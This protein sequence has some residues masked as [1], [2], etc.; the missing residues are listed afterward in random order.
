M[1]PPVSAGRKLQLQLPGSTWSAPVLL[2]AAGTHGLLEIDAA[3][4]GPPSWPATP[5]QALERTG[6][7][8]LGLSINSCP[9]VFG[10][11]K[12]LTISPRVLLCNTLPAHAIAYKQHGSAAAGEVVFP[13]DNAPFHWLQPLGSRL[14]SVSVLSSAVDRADDTTEALSRCDWSCAFP[15]ADVGDCTIV[16]KPPD[17]EARRK[18]LF[19]NVDVQ[20]TGAESR[21]VF[22]L[23]DATLAPY[24]IDNLTAHP[25]LISQSACAELEHPRVF[26]EVPPGSRLPFAWEQIA[27]APTVDVHVAGMRV[28]IK[29]D[30]LQLKGQ[31][32]LPPSDRPER[33]RFRTAPDGPIKVLQLL[34]DGPSGRGSVGA[35]PHLSQGGDGR[36]RTTL[37]VA[38]ASLGLSLV[39]RTPRELLYCSASSV[40]LDVT[41]SREHS[42]V[43]LT[44][45][46]LQVDNQLPSAVFPVLLQPSWSA[47]ETAEGRTPPPALELRIQCNFSNPGLAFYETVSLRVQTV[48]LMVDT[49]ARQRSGTNLCLPVPPRTLLYHAAAAVHATSPRSA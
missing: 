6:N 42:S 29:L 28:A 45:R 24:R 14:L 48:Q 5:G 3:A 20:V 31:I 22:S 36:V 25:L 4:S 30:D 1:M 32:T 37:T 49:L 13:G 15:I 18:K 26:D 8:Q 11:S 7:Y 44:V 40:H 2:E 43:A 38:V 35:T 19:L 9:G 34:S 39:D 46:A 33:L 16:L 21:V 12:M 27:D 41:S 23:Q 10:R 17:P 47:D